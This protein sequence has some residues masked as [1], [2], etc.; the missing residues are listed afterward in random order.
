MKIIEITIKDFKYDINLIDKVVAE[1]ERIDSN[2]EEVQL[3]VKYYQ[4]DITWYR[5]LI[6][7][8]KSQ[9]MQ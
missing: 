6:C 2:F 7:E 1:F 8:R 4:T 3:W 5:E 9:L